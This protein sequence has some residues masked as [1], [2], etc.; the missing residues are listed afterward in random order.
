MVEKGNSIRVANLKKIF[1][2]NYVL[3]GIS[4]EIKEKGL[5]L[6]VG[7]NGAGKTTLFKILSLILFPSE[8]EIFYNGERVNNKAEIFLKYI[9]FISHNPLLYPDL[10]CFENLEFSS[11]F[12]NIPKE[13][14]LELSEVFET[15]DYLNKKVKELSRGQIQRISLIK[16]ILH[17]P[18]F[19]YLDEP[20]NSLDKKGSKILESYIFEN[21][22]KKIICISSHS[23]SE[24][25]EESKRIFYLQKGEIVK[26]E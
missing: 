3:K 12:F 17:D 13:R 26:E 10:T 8:G 5:Y 22:D 14:I 15:K 7:D 9:G 4:F 11:K 19:L 6:F 2:R 24:I 21:M 16:S 18:I 20:F 23:Y 1:K 25:F